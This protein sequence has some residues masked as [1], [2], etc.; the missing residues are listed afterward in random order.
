MLYELTANGLAKP[1]LTTVLIWAATVAGRS[2]AT[3]RTARERNVALM[4]DGMERY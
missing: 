4:L 3:A 2:A 1:L